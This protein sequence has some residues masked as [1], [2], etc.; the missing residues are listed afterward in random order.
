[1]AGSVLACALFS[2]NALGYAFIIAIGVVI[3]FLTELEYYGLERI[4]S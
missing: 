4:V 1:V 3:A 2:P